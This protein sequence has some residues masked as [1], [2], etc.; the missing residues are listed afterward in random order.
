[1]S[2][3]EKPKRLR[4]SFQLAFYQ[5]LRYLSYLT[6]ITHDS[7]PESTI[8]SISKGVEFKGVNVWI[9]VFAIIIASVGL[10]VNSTAVIIGAMLV[11]P[12]M[13]PIMGLGLSI[14]ISDNELLRRSLKNYLTMVIISLIASTL[15]FLV[16]PLS[17]AQSELLARTRPTIFD[18]LI[19]FFGGLAGI[20]AGSRKQG[21]MIT[22][23]SGVAIATALMPPL[24]TAGYGLATGQLNYFI[25]AFYL[26]FINSFFIALATFI[27]V[28]Y[29]KFPV[30]E[31]VDPNKHRRVKRSIAIFSLLT[32]IP[33][34]I[35]AINVVKETSFNSSSIKYIN[36][37][38]RSPLF[39]DIQIVSHKREYHRKDK[40]LFL[41]VVGTEL[42]QRQ[43]DELQMRLL[44]YG[45][46]D[47]KLVIKQAGGGVLD[48]G[49]QAAMLQR[50]IEQ[51]DASIA[52][53]DSLIAQLQESL[54]MEREQ[55]TITSEQIAN[56]L[57]ALYPEI[58]SL[59]LANAMQMNLKTK[60]TDT[61]P[62]ITIDWVEKPDARTEAQV[63][64]WLL[65][66]LN[67]QRISIVNK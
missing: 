46:K 37:L 2:K 30:K 61:L 26:F 59:S 40:K 43:V 55:K 7:D 48:V 42:S 41:T 34:F 35:I 45:L 5:M 19:A 65:K 62:L 12:L 14:G 4:E 3:T 22:V 67:V 24:C 56:E 28:R 16:S 10:N 18:V 33:S 11:S 17:D 1:M 15:Y 29:M 20:V 49:T 47:T 32:I 9:L 36:D 66:R 21:G 53:K 38:E 57:S 6:D 50:F 23:V 60:K 13:G 8:A 58:E 54:S 64:R 31:F 63:E 27:M 39:E 25:G 44:D 52:H 51:K